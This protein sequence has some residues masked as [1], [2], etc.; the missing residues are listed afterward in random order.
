MGSPEN[1]LCTVGFDFDDGQLMAIDI[2]DISVLR[3]SGS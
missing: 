1:V 3:N 2:I